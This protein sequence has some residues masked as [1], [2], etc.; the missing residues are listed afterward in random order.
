MASVERWQAR[1]WQVEIEYAVAGTFDEVFLS[2]PGRD[3]H[4]LVAPEG[5][6]VVVDPGGSREEMQLR[7]FDDLL[8]RLAFGWVIRCGEGRPARD[9]VNRGETL[10]AGRVRSGDLADTE[11]T[12]LLVQ[13]RGGLMRRPCDAVRRSRERYGEFGLAYVYLWPIPGRE[14]NVSWGPG[15]AGAWSE[16]YDARLPEDVEWYPATEVERFVERFAVDQGISDEAAAAHLRNLLL[17]RGVTASATEATV[18]VERAG[19]RVDA[20][21]TSTSVHLLVNGR[22][23]DAPRERM[24]NEPAAEMLLDA[25][26]WFAEDSRVWSRP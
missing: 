26:D 20:L 12:V 15:F 2:R 13:P 25:A 4:A 1:G 16:L 22:R 18:T 10:F 9:K 24:P 11:V 19:I 7:S 21:V 5:D 17:L 3:V 6:E 14:P 23:V 8:D